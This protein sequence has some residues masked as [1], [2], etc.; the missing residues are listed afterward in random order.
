MFYRGIDKV[1]GSGLG[2]YI[3]KEHLDK[4]GGKISV[5]SELEMGTKFEIEVPNLLD[6]EGINPDSNELKSEESIAEK[7]K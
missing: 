5:Q 7:N 4:L 6:Y 2:L 3:V 1:S